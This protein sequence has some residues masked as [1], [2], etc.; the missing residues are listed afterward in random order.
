MYDKY[1]EEAQ[2]IVSS[3]YVMYSVKMNLVM[4]FIEVVRFKSHP[5]S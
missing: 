2:R 3:S 5:P 1:Y 4:F